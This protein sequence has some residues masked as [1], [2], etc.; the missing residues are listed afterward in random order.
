MTCHDFERQWNELLDAES[1]VADGHQPAGSE[2]IE[3]TRSPA[4]DDAEARLLAHA[5]D[6]PACRPIA[7]R[8]QVLRQAIRAW[9]QA[10]VPPA[11]L[12]QRVL[13]AP[14]DTAARHWRVI[15]VARARRWWR[16]P[17]TPLRLLASGLAA[18][19]LLGLMLT[20]GL[21]WRGRRQ[22]QVRTDI[23][24]EASDHDLH[25]H[26]IPAD[27]PEPSLALDRALSEATAA[28][29]DLARSASEPAARIG[30]DVLDARPPIEEGPGR[31]PVDPSVR[32]SG[33]SS[34][35]L[36][37]LTLPLPSLERLGSDATAPSA[38]LQEVGDRLSA[39]VEPISDTA[40]HAF[41]FL[42]GPPRPGTGSRDRQSRST[43]ARSG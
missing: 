36:A 14:A 41:G 35:G 43:G 22:R 37:G 4:V 32:S 15:A 34:E 5:A 29:W 23:V 21:D 33:D 8:Y 6:C 7:A 28:T 26:A 10:P 40:R 38:V 2:P 20:N 24:R 3:V 39:G 42:L 27:A 25:S 17:R 30:R 12:V 31:R 13:S 9:R 11:D 18:L 19:V 1:G 16:D